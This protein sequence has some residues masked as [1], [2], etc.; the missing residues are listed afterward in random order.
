MPNLFIQS[1]MSVVEQ[2]PTQALHYGEQVD[3]KLEVAKFEAG[4]WS[5]P[6]HVLEIQGRQQPALEWTALPL[7]ES[8]SVMNSLD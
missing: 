5:M 4:I 8:V 2:E 6:L 1:E 3:L 7:S